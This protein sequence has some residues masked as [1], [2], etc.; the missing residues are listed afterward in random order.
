MGKKIFD[1]SHRGKW[2]LLALYKSI[3]E[4]SSIYGH[5]G[6]IPSDKGHFTWEKLNLVEDLKKSF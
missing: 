3:Y 2:D 1:L 5:F 4:C 6:R